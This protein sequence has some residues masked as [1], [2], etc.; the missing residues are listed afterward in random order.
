M[1]HSFRDIKGLR[2]V[3]FKASP[4]PAGDFPWDQETCTPGAQVEG[5]A[6]APV[7]G[8]CHTL[9]GITGSSSH[10]AGRDKGREGGERHRGPGRGPVGSSAPRSGPRWGAGKR[11][12]VDSGAG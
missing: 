11:L 5:G 4:C 3:R 6:G 7:T 2:G 8:I 10:Q 12:T 1:G 9:E